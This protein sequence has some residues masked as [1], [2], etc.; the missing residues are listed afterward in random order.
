MAR[1][2][3]ARRSLLGRYSCAR[4]TVATVLAATVVLA[5]APST[6]Q[7]ALP[8]SDLLQ[9]SL[10]VNP[11][12]PPRFR[13][14]GEA[15]A[16]G[17]NQAP[18]AGAFAAPS[19]IGATPVYGSPTGFGAGDTGFDAMN[20][21]KRKKRARAK[22][23]AAAAAQGDTTFAPLPNYNPPPPPPPPPPRKPPL[24]V[25]YPKAAAA[26]V[27]AS[28]PPPPDTAP[29][30]NPPPEVHPL[31][32][33][34][35]P[36]ATVP[37]PPPQ[38]FDYS[39]SPPPPTLPQPGTFA[40]G[41]QPQKPLPIAAG[42]PYAALGIRAGSFLL[43][44]SLDLSAS[45]SSNPEHGTGTPSAPY[46]VAAP[47]LQVRSDWERHALT[48]DISGSYTQYAT[49]N[50]VPS[51]N[52]PY[53]NSKIDGRV[54]VTRDTQ[55]LL[56]NRVIISTDN[57]GSPNLQA[58]LAQL[59][60][61]QDVGGTLGLLQQFNRLSLS[62]KG[63]IDRATY[64]PSLLT[65]GETAS[66]SDRNFDQYAGIF[67]AGY[68][69]DPGLKPFVEVAI[70]QRIHD[71]EF[72]RSGLQRA[73]TGDSVSV[74]SAV[75]LFGS[76][77]GEM[78]VGY[79]RRSY[80]DPTLPDIVGPIANGSLTWQATALTTAKL[81][82]TSQV[83]ETIVDGASGQF[84]HDLN[85]QIDHAFRTWLI[86]TLR[87]G[88]GTDDYVGSGL[89]DTRYFAS[90]GLAYKFSREVQVRAELRQD[91]QNGSPGL[92]YAATSMLVGLRLQ[93]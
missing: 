53:L 43:L 3:A 92:G 4:N 13:L 65:D 88:Y 10:Q 86:G 38:Y 41:T 56:E 15:T 8:S 81:T 26:R 59:P 76:L 89:A 72:D 18:P 57:P 31:T 61:N 5:P 19:R 91:W 75:A 69:I 74:G 48:A 66:N 70:D 68:E 34:T 90:V 52:V 62:L 63:T 32:A 87:V 6:E 17:G 2:L 71:E 77:T 23:G 79:L 39:A 14:P 20:T 33:A 54:D 80:Q 49:D 29:I 7:A 47:E 24:P 35:R 25:I 82:A 50:L 36:G 9:P 27:G 60:A 84:S 28:L 11:S 64:N 12:T 21:P 40:L 55:I 30:S 1:V 83:Y 85:L 22:A 51:L 58:Q 44:P 78:A 42:D 46:F 73:S 45:Y 16:A 93:R 67:R 37:I